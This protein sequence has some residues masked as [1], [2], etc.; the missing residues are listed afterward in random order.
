MAVLIGLGDAVA[1]RLDQGGSDGGDTLRHP[2]VHTPSREASSSAVI[3][4]STAKFIHRV[5]SVLTL[6]ITSIPLFEK[7]G[8]ST[9]R[10]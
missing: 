10:L 9:I 1:R 8:K 2:T 6:T 4:P 7:L 5:S 3:I